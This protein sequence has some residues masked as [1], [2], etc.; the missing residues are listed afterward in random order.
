MCQRDGLCQPSPCPSPSCGQQRRLRV[1]AEPRPAAA[2]QHG[3]SLVQVTSSLRVPHLYGDTQGTS[4]HG[5]SR[6]RTL[7][8]FQ[9][10]PDERQSP[11]LL[12]DGAVGGPCLGSACKNQAAL[13][14]QPHS[15]KGHRQA[16]SRHQ[17]PQHGRAGILCPPKLSALRGRLPPSSASED[18]SAFLVSPPPSPLPEWHRGTLSP[19][20]PPCLLHKL[21]PLR[22]ARGGGK[23]ALLTSAW[24]SSILSTFLAL[25]VL[26]WAREKEG[27]KVSSNAAAARLQEQCLGT[28][29]RPQRHSRRGGGSAPSAGA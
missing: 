27:K 11:P 15:R 9:N 24:P 7:P 5:S 13:R 12:L 23:A 22:R 14:E 19:S 2:T 1:P 16:A 26:H 28:E 17:Q 18:L 10:S 20:L 21:T 29:P 8:F 4:E 3:S 6:C 25:S